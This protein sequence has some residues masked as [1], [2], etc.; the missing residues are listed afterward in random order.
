MAF[1]LVKPRWQAVFAICCA[2]A[3]ASPASAKPK[4]PQPPAG[5]AYFG[6]ELRNLSRLEAA[7]LG[8]FIHGAVAATK[9]EP[10]SPAAAA[11]LVRGDIVLEFDGKPIDNAAQL[12]KAIGSKTPGTV[13]ALWVQHEGRQRIARVKLGVKPG[14]Q[15]ADTGIAAGE[16]AAKPAPQKQEPPAAV[17]SA[18]KEEA[19][20]PAGQKPGQPPANGLAALEAQIAALYAQGKYV[21]AAAQA[22]RYTA[23]AQQHPGKDHPAYVAAIAWQGLLYEEL[24]RYREAEP[25]L[26][27]A[28]EQRERIFGAEHLDTLTSVETL[29]ELY[30]CQ[31]RFSEAEPLIERAMKA[32]QRVA[33]TNAPG[34]FRS[35]VFRAHLYLVRG[36]HGE[37]GA[38]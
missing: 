19:P 36:Q 16:A 14:E 20:K 24:G 4:N 27:Q 21:E 28:L 8:V 1:E 26:K 6:T 11:G 9:V 31:A 5:H 18:P 13:V 22:E 29:G 30:V 33:G 17:A 7:S 10:N 34:T 38:S 2:L 25:L 37:V 15:P 35:M 23:Q 32:R 3:A 12:L